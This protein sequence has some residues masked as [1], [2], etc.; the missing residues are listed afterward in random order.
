MPVIISG[1]E[2]GQPVTLGSKKAQKSGRWVRGVMATCNW[3]KKKQDN[4]TK[5]Y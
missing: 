1:L 2:C 4:I 5:L 3:L